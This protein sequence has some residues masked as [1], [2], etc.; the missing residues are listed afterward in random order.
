MPDV[1]ISQLPVAA[2]LDG[3]EIFPCVQSLNTV[4]T[5]LADLS[6]FLGIQPVDE[7][8]EATA[9]T[10]DN[11]TT[12]LIVT[13]TTL[14]TTTLIKVDIIA[15]RTGGTAGTVGDSATW[16]LTARVKDV[17][18]VVTVHDVQT[19]YESKDQALMD[20]EIVIIGTNIVVRGVGTLNNNFDWEA[21]LTKR[22][23]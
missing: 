20:T 13:G 1:K 15:K 18:G 19:D 9:S 16:Q 22:I 14:D 21:R 3:S 4:R 11:T 23:I 10:T 7:V 8:V 5:T 6:G 2:S 17:S 12:N